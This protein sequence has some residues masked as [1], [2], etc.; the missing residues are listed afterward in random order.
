MELCSCPFMYMHMYKYYIECR[1]TCT[2]TCLCSSTC[3]SSYSCFCSCSCSC[4][5]SC[6]CIHV[7]NLVHAHLHIS[8]CLFFLFMYCEPCVNI[9]QTLTRPQSILTRLISKMTLDGFFY[10]RTPYKAGVKTKF[11]Q[12]KIASTIRHM[13][14]QTAE[15]GTRA[16]FALSRF[17]AREREAK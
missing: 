15:L 1:C 6:S 8:L 12:Y 16:F 2:W 13:K 4:S 14:W 5:Y 10:T 3:T 7:Q 17:C 9:R 11:I